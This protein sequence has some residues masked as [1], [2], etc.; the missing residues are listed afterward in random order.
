MRK[1]LRPSI[2]PSLHCSL[3]EIQCPTPQWVLQRAYPLC[4][5]HQVAFRRRVLLGAGGSESSSSAGASAVVSSVSTST[6]SVW[7]SLEAL[8]DVVSEAFS[9]WVCAWDR[10]KGIGE[11]CC[12]RLAAVS[13]DEVAGVNGVWGE[14][15]EE[16]GTWVLER[17]EKIGRPEVDTV[18]PKRPV[19]GDEDVVGG[20]AVKSVKLRLTIWPKAKDQIDSLA[21]SRKWRRNGMSH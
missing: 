4:P 18:P 7:S 16:E 12:A 11:D 20:R 1:P 2:P 10:L 6:K 13:L 15:A 21:I 3:Q 9:S 8:K 5:C 19:D 17:P 14:T